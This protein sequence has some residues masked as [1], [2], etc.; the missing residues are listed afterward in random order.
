MESDIDG[1]E[2][3]EDEDAMITEFSCPYCGASYTVRDT[4]KSEMKNYKYFN[5]KK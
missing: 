1:S 2:L 4:P 5:K 3:E